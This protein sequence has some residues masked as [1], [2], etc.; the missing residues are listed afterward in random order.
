MEKYKSGKQ[1]KR[2][3]LLFAFLLMLHVNMMPVSATNISTLPDGSGN[4]VPPGTEGAVQDVPVEPPVT[5]ILPVPQESG[6][7]LESVQEEAVAPETAVEPDISVTQEEADSDLTEEMSTEKEET[8]ENTIRDGRNSPETGSSE[9]E[10]AFESSAGESWPMG[11]SGMGEG[12]STEDEQAEEAFEEEAAVKKEGGSTIAK[13]IA[14]V[15]MVLLIG[16]VVAYGYFS[17]VA[18]EELRR[19]ERRARAWN[20]Y[21]DENDE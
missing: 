4:D 11:F 18:K 15:F 6:F 14:A 10:S 19:R 21:G 7:W 2:I 17:M 20:E 3:Y 8:E 16:G 5:E 13:V 9:T 1:I 12:Q